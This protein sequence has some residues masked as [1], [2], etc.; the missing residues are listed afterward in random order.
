MIIYWTESIKFLADVIARNAYHFL[1]FFYLIDCFGNVKCLLNK[2]LTVIKRL[3][4]VTYVMRWNETENIVSSLT[5]ILKDVHSITFNHWS[6]NHKKRL[7]TPM[8]KKLKQEL[9]N[10]YFRTVCEASYGNNY[11]LNLI[12]IHFNSE[13]LPS[14][15]VQT[16]LLLLIVWSFHSVFLATGLVVFQN[17]TMPDD[18]VCLWLTNY[19]WPNQV[20]WAVSHHITEDNSLSRK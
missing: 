9:L 6:Y 1:S 17:N 4:F 3:L 15:D 8:S 19:C 2:V 12:W 7:Q 18:F 16:R 14:W 13:L 5:C 11:T 10:L 20:S